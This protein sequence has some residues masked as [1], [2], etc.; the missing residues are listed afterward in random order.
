M[1]NQVNTIEEGLNYLLEHFQKPLFPRTVSTRSTDNKQIV[2]WSRDE[3]LW[4]FNQARLQDCRINAYSVY[5]IE[6]MIPNLIFIDLDNVSALDE[7]LVNF[8]KLGANP[9]VLFTGNGLAI[10]QPIK[11]ES[12][13]HVSHHGN[14]AEELAKLFMQFASRHLSNN[15]CDSGNH[16]SLKSCLIRVPTSI[17]SKNGNVVLVKQCW[18]GVRADVSSIPFKEYLIKI[19]KEGEYTETPRVNSSQKFDY[20]EK[21]LDKK[22][23]DCRKRVCDLVILPYLINIKNLPPHSVIEN[24]YNHFDGHIPIQRI[25]YVAKL[26]YKNKH[27]PYGQTGMRIKDPELYAMVMM[28]IQSKG[29][30]SV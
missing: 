7:T 8:N 15:K 14:C 25:R 19:Q 16:P 1:T 18:D 13:K 28:L 30:K 11:M 23:T 3:V 10:I 21:L 27:L 2:V 4:Y 24:V 6:N 5:E 29:A 17:N 26:L 22:L 20:I 9:S 12:W